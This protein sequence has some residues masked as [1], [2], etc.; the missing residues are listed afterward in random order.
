MLG[1][2]RKLV[3]G[4]LLVW[5]LVACSPAP[6]T[7]IDM[8]TYVQRVAN[9]LDQPAPPLVFTA[10]PALPHHR[11]RNQP[12]PELREGLLDV[13]DLK[14]CNL[15]PLIAE[16]NSSLGKVYAPS[17]QMRYEIRFVARLEQCLPQLQTATD[18]TPERKAELL[19]LY[20]TKQASVPKVLWNALFTGQEFEE[21][22]ALNQPPLP[23]PAA[24]HT[25]AFQA[26]D[27]LAYIT[28]T[29]LN[30]PKALDETHFAPLEAHYGALYSDPLGIP[31]LR[32]LHQLSL[33]LNAVSQMIEQRLAK[34]PFCFPGMRNPDAD[35][36]K[37]VFMRFY[38][39]ELQP[40]LAYVHRTAWRWL[41]IQT[42][43]L[44]QLPTPT[45]FIPY[46]E[47]MLRVDSAQSLWQHYEAARNRHT[48]A[49]QTLLRQCNLMPGKSS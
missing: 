43:L 46:T 34:R 4:G 40:Y 2:K 13:L 20:Q 48:Q 18:I 10:L 21:S 23:W 42:Q 5:M 28:T 12:L 33:T 35:I 31:S 8:Q 44:K 1:N 14:R 27:Y 15:L 30:D 26:L 7:A 47:Q 3:F 39:G 6:D 49:W 24:D 16:R 22:L 32:A 25:A 9:V 38:A 29:A 36:L 37:Q 45:A 19:T 17:Q 41:T 11:E